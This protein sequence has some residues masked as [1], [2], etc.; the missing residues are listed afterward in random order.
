MKHKLIVL[1]SI[2]VTNILIVGKPLPSSALPAK[3][4]SAQPAKSASARKPKFPSAMTWWEKR[5]LARFRPQAT[6]AN[7]Y[8]F[9]KKMRARK[10]QTSP[11]PINTKNNW[12]CARIWRLISYPFRGTT[13][14]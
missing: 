11:N 12:L 5:D 13:N 1:V 6:A 7:G 10:E 8:F 2:L 4:A 9:L 14:S 3:S